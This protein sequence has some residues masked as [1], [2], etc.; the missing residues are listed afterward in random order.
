MIYIEALLAFY[1]AQTILVLIIHKLE[2][3][4]FRM[5]YFIQTF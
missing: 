3:T 2:N 4:V 1:H 5:E